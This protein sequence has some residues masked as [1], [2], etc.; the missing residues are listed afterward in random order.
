MR[1][2]RHTKQDRLP[3]NGSR[4]R[5]GVVLAVACCALLSVSSGCRTIPIGTPEHCIEEDEFTVSHIV[6]T[7]AVFVF[8]P[9]VITGQPTRFT[10]LAIRFDYLEARCAGIN[11]FRGDGD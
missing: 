4:K 8:K 11:A 3:K 7:Q 2:K 9:D 1:G 5:L 6:D 10:E